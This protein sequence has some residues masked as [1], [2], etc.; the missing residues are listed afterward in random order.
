[1]SSLKKIIGLET[2]NVDNVSNIQYMFSNCTKL[3]E[4]NLPSFNFDKISS[5]EY[6][7]NSCYE[8]KTITLPNFNFSKKYSNTEYMFYRNYKLEKIYVSENNGNA[9]V[10]SKSTHMFD[11]CTSL[12]GGAGTAYDPTFTDATAARIDGGPNNPGYFT[13]IK[14]KQ[15]NAASF[16]ETLDKAPLLTPNEDIKLDTSYTEDSLDTTIIEDKADTPIISE[17]TNSK[18]IVDSSEE[19]SE[20]SI[21]ET[22]SGNE[23]EIENNKENNEIGVI[24]SLINE[25]KN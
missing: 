2:L 19:T 20:P 16:D 5:L 11:G 13:D 9:I 15:V 4:I 14:D 8:L 12:V 10:A 17:S 23:K 18:V 1:M 25:E 6:L 21:D 22:N 24:K 3:E 7:F